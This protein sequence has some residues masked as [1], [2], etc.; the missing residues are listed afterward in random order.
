[1]AERI[2]G[3]HDD[4][5]NR[6]MNGQEQANAEQSDVQCQESEQ[7]VR[8]RWCWFDV[9]PDVR[10]TGVAASPRPNGLARNGTNTYALAG[11]NAANACGCALPKARL[12]SVAMRHRATD[13]WM[14]Q[15]LL[16]SP[17]GK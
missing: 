15:V 12:R 3:P 8:V 10:H 6:Q 7:R 11:R 5:G 16:K 1:M 4:E 2:Q 9:D 14:T 17:I 13:N